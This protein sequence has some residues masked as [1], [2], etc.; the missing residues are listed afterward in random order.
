MFCAGPAASD[1]SRTVRGGSPERVVDMLQSRKKEKDNTAI[2]F[3]KY[4][5]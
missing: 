5:P 1:G 2:L 3:K 4:T